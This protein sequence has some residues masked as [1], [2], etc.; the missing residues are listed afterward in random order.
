MKK[1]FKK[2][3]PFMIPLMVT[4][5]VVFLFQYIF[6]FGY[7]PTESMEPTLKAGSFILGIR[8]FDHVEVGDIIVFRYEDSYLVKRV[9][10]CV[11]DTVIHKN[12]TLIVPDGCFFVLGDNST[13]SFDSRYWENPFVS[14]DE[15]IAK[16]M[17]DFGR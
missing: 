17:I 2:F 8:L 11:G 15:V 10:A 3:R 6:M 1:T 16:M 13:N 7:V 9:A 4:L 12:K 5:L 14:I